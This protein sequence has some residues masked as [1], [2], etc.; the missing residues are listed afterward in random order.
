[1]ENAE[2]V[3][4]A[5][6]KVKLTA[7][8]GEL[9]KLDARRDEITKEVEHIEYVI[10]VFGKKSEAKTTDAVEKELVKLTESFDRKSAIVSVMKDFDIVMTSFQI[11]SELKKKGTPIPQDSFN[12]IMSAESKKE[13]SNIEKVGYGKYRYRKKVDKGT[14]SSLASLAGAAP[15]GENAASISREL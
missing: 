6:L 2:I 10:G 13:S 7:L 1:M 3:S 9:R 12:A 4:I 14:P 15:S 5:D 11:R 8:N